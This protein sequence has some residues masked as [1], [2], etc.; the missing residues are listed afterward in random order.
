MLDMQLLN[1]Y[2]QNVDRSMTERRRD[3]PPRMQTLL[4]ESLGGERTDRSKESYAFAT[5]R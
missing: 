5:R 1:R 3:F 2:L 4:V